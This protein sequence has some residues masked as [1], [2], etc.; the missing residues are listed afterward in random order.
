MTVGSAVNTFS[1][2]ADDL[3]FARFL[4]VCS[5]FSV[6]RFCC[7]KEADLVLS[8]LVC[9]YEKS[10]FSRIVEVPRAKLNKPCHPAVLWLQQM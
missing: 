5:R 10:S 1:T 6:D 4:A 2:W 3:S 9:E 8:A 7:D